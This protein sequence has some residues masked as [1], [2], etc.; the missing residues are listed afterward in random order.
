MNFARESIL[1][2]SLWK[3]LKLLSQ[4][5]Q[6]KIALL[7]IVVAKLQLDSLTLSSKLSPSVR[8][9]VDCMVGWLRTGSS[10]RGSEAKSWS[11][12]GA[13]DWGLV[14]VLEGGWALSVED[15]W[16][17]W[18]GTETEVQ[19]GHGILIL[20]YGKPSCAMIGTTELTTSTTGLYNKR[21]WTIQ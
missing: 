16:L 4:N 20:R 3:T 11:V 15:C 14:L 8:L 6:A 2:D 1:P 12:E 13:G 19:Q 21:N 7:S 17:G 10:A 18:D 9:V 5:P